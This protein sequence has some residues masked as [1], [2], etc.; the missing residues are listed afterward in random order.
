ME[1]TF[2][3]IVIG[4]T[5]TGKTSIIHQFTRGN[6]PEAHFTTPLPI[7]HSKNVCGCNLDIWD[8]A[9]ADEWQSMNS[10]VYHGSNA[11]IYLCAYDSQKSLSDLKDEWYPKMTTFLSDFQKVKFFLAVNKSDLPKEE[12]TIEENEIRQIQTEI[13]AT[14]LFYVSAKENTNV[15]ELFEAVANELKKDC[16]SP[17]NEIR[18]TDQ[19]QQQQQ[20]DK[21]CC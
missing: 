2:K 8:T 7:E 21:G 18:V 17:S 5:Y 12:Q 3:V 1:K 15:K 14:Q 16:T 6:F 13:N 11:V 19:Q 20:K 10:S 4:D 9:G